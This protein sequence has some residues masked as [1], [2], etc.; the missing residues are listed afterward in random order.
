MVRQRLEDICAAAAVDF[1]ALLSFLRQL[2]RQF[3]VAVLVVHHARKDA[4]STRPGQALRG[5]SELH[6]WGDSNLYMRRRGQQLTLSTEH[7]AAASQDHIPLALTQSGS[8]MALS[9][10]NGLST[11]ATTEPAA[12]PSASERVRQALAKLTEPASVQRL[13]ELCA[14]RTTTVCSA[15][16]Q[17][18]QQGVVS[19]DDRGYQLKLT[20]PRE[21]SVSLS[22]P[23]DPQG[24]GNGKCTDPR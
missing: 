14:M 19:R 4:H 8:A 21:D 15:L 20:L 10:M 11:A 22:H 16:A 9:V 2:Q 6:G 5:S 1:A 23:I 24:N 3:R 17:L 7:R 13:R 12:A 18:S